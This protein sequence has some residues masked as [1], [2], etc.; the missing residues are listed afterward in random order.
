MLRAHHQIG[1]KRAGG[2]RVGLLVVKLLQERC[3]NAKARLWINR[4]EPLTES[5]ECSECRWRNGGNALRL[6]C[7]WWPAE[8]LTRAPD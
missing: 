3:G 5:C 8:S 6:V 7:G 4:L 1:I 2:C